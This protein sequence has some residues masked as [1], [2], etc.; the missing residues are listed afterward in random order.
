MLL[1][2]F[3]TLLTLAMACAP[4]QSVDRATLTDA[5]LEPRPGDARPNTAG[6]GG[7]AGNGGAG[8]NIDAPVDLPRDLA[9]PDRAPDR[10]PDR[11]PDAAPPPDTLP[12]PDVSDAVVEAPAIG[13][14]LLVVGDPAMPSGADNRIRAALVAKNFVVKLAD[15]NAQP[16]V[17]DV[18]LVVLS[19]S[20]ASATLNGRYRD[21]P[22]PVISMESADFDRMGMTAAAAADFGETAG[23]QVSITDPM[24][25][26][27]AGLM[28]N[29]V[30]VTA[31]STLAWG[32]P[33]PGAQKVA[34]MPNAADHATIFAYP[35][36]AMMVMGTAIAPRV[37][38]FASDDAGG[39]MNLNALKLLGAAIDWALQ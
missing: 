33:G 20:S 39:R 14:A 17:T 13:T 19:G 12:P 31:S 32:R 15:D 22:V 10:S 29:V 24:H 28:G 3:L 23:T 25:P 38:F 9:G 16:D 6:T 2:R 26:I 34:T 5:S 18:R 21:V 8:G 35:T 37:G 4:P 11:A 7:S 30:V 1:Q 27:A 36:G